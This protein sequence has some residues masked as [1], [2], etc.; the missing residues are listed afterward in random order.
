M[1]QPMLRDLPALTRRHQRADG[2]FDLVFSTAVRGAAAPA[3]VPPPMARRWA[4]FWTML[5]AAVW[6]PASRFP[7]MAPRAITRQ[8]AT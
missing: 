2:G 8:D 7:A 5:Q 4:R 1:V 6:S 3:T